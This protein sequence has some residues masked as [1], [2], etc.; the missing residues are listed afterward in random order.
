MAEPK[1][2]SRPAGEGWG[3]T[4]EVALTPL[5]LARRTRRLYPSREAVVDGAVRYTY[6]QFFDRCDRFASAGVHN[7]GGG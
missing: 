7:A 4:V 6:E 5:E 3:C 2:G 1:L